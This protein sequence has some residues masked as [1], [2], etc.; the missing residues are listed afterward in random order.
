MDPLAATFE[1]SAAPVLAAGDTLGPYVVVRPL[2][3]GA[4]GS[5][6]E[7][8]GPN[9]ER[10][11]VKALH[12]PGAGTLPRLVR[13]AK[14]VEGIVHPNVC[15]I[16]G[17]RRLDDGSAILVLELLEGRTLQ[18]A[19]REGPLPVHRAIELTI[20]MAR[21]LQVL[22][23]LG[24]VHRD[25]KPANV[26]LTKHNGVEVPKIMDFG[27][28][29][30]AA[31]WDLTQLTATNGI[32]G[33]PAYMSPEQALTPAEI[34]PRSDLYSLGLVL[35]EM[36]AGRRPFSGA[37][38]AQLIV[39]HAQAIPPSVRRFRPE[40]SP[41]L[42]AVV[43]R[44]LAKFPEERP[45]TAA[46]L[47]AQLRAAR[48]QST[49]PPIIAPR[50][51]RRSWVAGLAALAA[52]AAVAVVVIPELRPTLS[53]EERAAP[54][55]PIVQSEPAEPVQSASEERVE[56]PATPW[57]YGTRDRE[58]ELELDQRGLSRADLVDFVESGAE[59]EAVRDRKVTRRELQTTAARVRRQIQ[60]EP[61][62]R[63][64]L[65]RKLERLR[66]MG[67]AERS[68]DAL[69]K[70]IE[71]APEHQ[72]WV[73]ARSLTLRERWTR[74]AAARE[75]G[76]TTLVDHLHQE[77]RRALTEGRFED[78]ERMLEQCVAED[79]RHPECHRELSRLY[80]LEK[81]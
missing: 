44:C 22:H 2:G 46:E 48:G 16:F 19:I 5:V 18:D 14:L 50:P 66:R 28:A 59:W 64:F 15:R 47:E 54:P 57:L 34:D 62:T 24:I 29:K 53:L 52:A 27:V 43:A 25:L 61:M 37:E 7:G 20:Q 30:A 33:T 51:R 31:S 71:S 32:V 49:A 56:R 68:A 73:E 79:P 35:F 81:R 45:A 58:I 63:A 76:P 17:A 41:E 60:D 13:E 77:G 26:F 38:P 55:A 36:L 65:R 39:A 75:A 12:N 3:S 9:G 23:A 42:S 1:R 40:V 70:S 4:H 8:Q 69:A 78:A 6:F 72:L 80:A 21:G 74:S 11:A 67:L 10:V